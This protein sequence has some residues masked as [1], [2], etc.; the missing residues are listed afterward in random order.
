[1]ESRPRVRSRLPWWGVALIL[2]AVPVSLPFF[3]QSVVMGAIAFTGGAAILHDQF[4]G[5]PLL[6]KERVSA[7]SPDGFRRLIAERDGALRIQDTRS[8]RVLHRARLNP[9][10]VRSVEVVRWERDN[11]RLSAAIRYPG[12]MNWFS[13]TWDLRSDTLRRN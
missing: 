1:M 3:A 10:D 13:Y 12:K 4:S 11:V 8:G 6:L 7:V 9:K 5:R 2:L